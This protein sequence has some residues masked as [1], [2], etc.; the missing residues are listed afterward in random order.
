MHFDSMFRA[1]P[2][3][4][5]AGLALLGAAGCKQQ[6]TTYLL[7]TA[8]R[9]PVPYVLQADSV[10]LVQL[11]G[12]QIILDQRAFKIDYTIRKVCPT[13]STPLPNPGTRGRY[14]IDQDVIT[15]QDSLGRRMDRGE[16][17]G[18]T[19][20]VNGKQHTLRFVR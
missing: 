18:D 15:F 10:C 13:G 11:M 14:T 3:A 1:H 9:S 12:G 17:R 16:K 7:R 20:V 2:A 6:P 8:D 19:I 4:L 5:V